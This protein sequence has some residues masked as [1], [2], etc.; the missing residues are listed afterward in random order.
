M[1]GEDLQ[2]F[3]A[4][5][6]YVGSMQVRIQSGERLQSWQQQYEVRD[7]NWTQLVEAMREVRLAHRDRDWDRVAE[8]VTDELG[9]DSDEEAEE[10]APETDAEMEVPEAALA[11]QQE[12]ESARACSSLLYWHRAQIRRLRFLSWHVRVKRESHIHESCVHPRAH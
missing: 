7:G 10:E 2:S 1:H 11:L 9:S 6:Y 4:Q 5:R 8:I 3:L 12:I